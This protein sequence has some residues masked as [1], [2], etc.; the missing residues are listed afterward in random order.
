MTDYPRTT[1]EQDTKPSK[2]RTTATIFVQIVYAVLSAVIVIAILKIAHAGCCSLVTIDPVKLYDQHGPAAVGIPV[3][4]VSAL[5]LVS[6]ARALDGPMSLDLF[7][8]K[9]GG[10]SATCIIWAMLFLVIGL[11]FRAHW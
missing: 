9:S 8:V 7:G 10:A 5:F 3:A 4:G 2:W 1:A 11:T 6:L